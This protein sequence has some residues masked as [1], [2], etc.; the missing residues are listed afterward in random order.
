LKR[1]ILGIIL[2]TI[3]CYFFGFLYWGL[4]P[5]PYTSWERTPDDEAAGQALLEHF[6]TSGTYYIPS[7]DNDEA[8]LARLHE[9]GPIGFVH[10]TREG[11][12]V[13]QSDVMAKGFLL[14]FI[15]SVL[16]A[17]LLKLAGPALPTY[18][19]VLKFAALA[20]FT[21][22]VMIDLGDSVWWHISWGWKLHMACYHVTSWVI[23]GLVL[24]RFTRDKAI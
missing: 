7:H 23:A 5:L 9:A 14:T 22:A 13:M 8:T 12:P 24:A 3:A 10:I 4:N 16:I 17:L 18:G 2:A 19:A 20:G 1:T 11:K 6:P 15:T 21:A